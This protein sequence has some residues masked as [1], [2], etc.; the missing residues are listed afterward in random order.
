LN[1]TAILT[2]SRVVINKPVA[3]VWAFFDNPDNLGMWLRGHTEFTHLSGMRGQPGAKS[4]HI[5]LEKGRRMGLEEESVRRVEGKEFAG[6]LR[7]KGIMENTSTTRS[8][9]LG[10]GRTDQL[11]GGRALHQRAV[12][13]H[14]ALHGRRVP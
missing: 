3:E 6:I 12:E 7:M 4:V 14:G 13:V 2:T 11:R 9:T 5:Y 1:L 8:R 10:D